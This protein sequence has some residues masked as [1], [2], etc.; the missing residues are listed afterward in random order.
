MGESHRKSYN[1]SKSVEFR[2]V[3]L[4][5]NDFFMI[6]C[7]HVTVVGAA[8]PACH[9]WLNGQRRQSRAT[10]M[11]WSRRRVC[12]QAPGGG[13]SSLTLVRHPGLGRAIDS[14]LLNEE[15]L[16]KEEM[17]HPPCPEFSS[18]SMLGVYEI[19]KTSSS[20]PSL[21]AWASSIFFPG[22]P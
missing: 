18:G 21:L 19:L 10:G 1:T 17:T 15:G 13:A 6:T 14:Y 2:C 5:S 3:L 12:V 7:N 22:C 20:C 9:V 11:W 4:K 8:P 16:R